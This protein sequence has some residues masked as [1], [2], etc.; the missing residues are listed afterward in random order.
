MTTSLTKK[1]RLRRWM[2]NR[3]LFKN[4]YMKIRKG[5]MYTEEELLALEEAGQ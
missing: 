3:W 5:K 4:V 2:Y 1:Q